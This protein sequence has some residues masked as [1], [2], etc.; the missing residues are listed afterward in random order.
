LRPRIDAYVKKAG[1]TVTGFLLRAAEEKL[2]REEAVPGGKP[3]HAYV[4]R[5]R[6]DP[7]Y[8]CAVCGDGREL[9]KRARHAEE[10]S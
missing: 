10:V 3:A 6:G 8:G 2:D 9:H 7:E 4:Q 5:E 1:G